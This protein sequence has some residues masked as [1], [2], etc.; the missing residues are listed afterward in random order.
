LIDGS[1]DLLSQIDGIG[2]HWL[3]SPYCLLAPAFPSFI[4]AHGSTFWLPAVGIN[5][6]PLFPSK[7]YVMIATG[8]LPTIRIGRAVR[9]S[10]SA[11][12][13]WVEERE[14]Q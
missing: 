12:G 7:M 9:V 1:Q 5:K 11:L 4:L 3:S 6:S 13:K 14:Q 8:E 10:S 2:F